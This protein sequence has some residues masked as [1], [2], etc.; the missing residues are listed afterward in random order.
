MKTLLTT[1]WGFSRIIRLVMGIL[2]I[3]YGFQRHDLMLGV[4]G[5][6]LVFMGLMNLGC[7]GS[8]GCNTSVKMR[9]PKS[10]DKKPEI[11]QYEE[12]H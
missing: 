3:V 10:T 11:T 4:A 5:G 9:E 1:G 2:A 6:F 7:C 12:V 8:G